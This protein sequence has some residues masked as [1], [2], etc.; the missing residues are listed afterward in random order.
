[1]KMLDNFLIMSSH[2]PSFPL[3]LQLDSAGQVW[4]VRG[5]Q[6]PRRTKLSAA[7]FVN[8]GELDTKIH[9]LGTKENVPLLLQLWQNQERYPQMDLYVGTPRFA[10]C[11]NRV[12]E[13][14]SATA[15]A[16]PL[17]PSQGGWRQFTH[18]DAI[19]YELATL[20]TDLESDIIRAGQLVVRHPIWPL[21]GFILSINRA[22]LGF[23][24][25]AVRDPRWYLSA[26]DPNSTAPL[27]RYLGLWP[28][29]QAALFNGDTAALKSRAGINCQL[30]T[31]CWL[32]VN[33]AGLA[34]CDI[35]QPGHFLV[36]A[37]S[38]R[39]PESPVVGIVRSSQLFTR[40]ARAIWLSQTS[41]YDLFDPRE[42]LRADE[43][44]SFYAFSETVLH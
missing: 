44:P 10:D 39:C 2:A 28:R 5:G 19:S 32:P 17:G 20:R 7:D 9:I 25:G 24:V 36:R 37:L 21:V 42:F 31:A 16:P 33:E 11:T 8:S 29:L 1:M 34:A 30:T 35:Q 26:K 6:S 41:G 4:S 23:W 43:L 40:F 13:M 27:E 15:A 38:R 3:V 18:V 14:L 22:A 12:S